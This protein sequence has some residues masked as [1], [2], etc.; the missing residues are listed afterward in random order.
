MTNQLSDY[1]LWLVLLSYGVSV[2]GALTG[3]MMTR[4]IR[5][6]D[7]G[8]SFIWLSAAAAV[9]GGCAIWSMHFLGMIAYEP[10]TLVSY[11]IA[12]T[13]ASFVVP[14]LLTGLG[15]YCVFNWRAS[16][17]ALV[18]G[19]LFM[20]T[21]VATM[22][23]AGMAAM[24]MSASMSYD[25]TLLGLSLVIA[26]AAST[27]ALWMFERSSGTF[28]YASAPVLGIAVCG[29]HYTGMAA[30]R[31]TAGNGAV[32]YYNGAIN[33]DLMG[34]PVTVVALSACAAGIYMVIGESHRRHMLGRRAAA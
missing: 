5:Q 18:A 14:V 30:M 22:H 9:I 32:D 24:R 21:G 26:L 8:I 4:Y 28:R 15:L 34:L 27:V 31:L 16:N 19:G 23:Y 3:L 2:A 10:G 20:G 25:P 7:G 6:P 29:M 17:S 12:I 33:Q 11:D 1:N 13:G